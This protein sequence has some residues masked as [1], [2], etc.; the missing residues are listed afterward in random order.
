MFYVGIEEEDLWYE[1]DN[2]DEAL[3][4]AIEMEEQYPN[5]KIHFIDEDENE[6]DF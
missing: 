3:D 4:C 2:Y 5:E 1:F 6:I